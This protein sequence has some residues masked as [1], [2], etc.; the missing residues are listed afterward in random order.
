MKTEKRIQQEI[1]NYYVN[2]FCL[3]NNPNRQMFFHIAN[4]NQH[5]LTGIGVVAGVADLFLTVKKKPIFVEVKT[6]G[7]KQ[8]PEQKD[9]EKLCKA[10][11]IPYYIVRSLDDFKKLIEE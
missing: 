3:P 9:F 5:R 8:E 6:P 11:G 2:N 10:M 7:G 4:E 1:Y